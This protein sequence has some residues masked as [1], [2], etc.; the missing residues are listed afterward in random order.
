LD[1]PELKE[2]LQ[3][4]GDHDS[5]AKAAEGRKKELKSKIVDFGDDGNFKC[6]GYSISRHMPRTTYDMKQ[7]KM[8]G[9]NLDKYAK[10]H[11]GIGYYKISVPKV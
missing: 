5:V 1:D 8:D 9:I 7:M 11:Q 10:N 6:N 3:E 4:Y 2:L